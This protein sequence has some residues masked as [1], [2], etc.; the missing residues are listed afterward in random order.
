MTHCEYCLRKM[1]NGERR[2]KYF[3]LVIEPGE[4]I[5]PDDV[6]KHVN[7]HHHKIMVCK[8]CEND[9]FKKEMPME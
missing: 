2:V 8:K 5:H 4:Y 3:F 6:E 9:I 1:K 7:E